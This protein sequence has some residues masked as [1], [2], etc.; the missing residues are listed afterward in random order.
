MPENP[1]A[2]V[3]I[4]QVTGAILVLRGYNPQPVANCDRFPEAPRSAL[5]TLR[6]H[7]ARR[8]HGRRD[9]KQPARG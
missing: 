3:P 9:L 6:L 4:E 7:R 1:L 8:D 5:P 2:P